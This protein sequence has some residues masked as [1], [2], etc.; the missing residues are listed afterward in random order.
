MPSGRPLTGQGGR[1]GE[2]TGRAA[3][4][5]LG[6][7]PGPQPTGTA[8]PSWAKCR[9]GARLADGATVRGAT[10][11]IGAAPTATT[12]AWHRPGR[13]IEVR[14]ATSLPPVV[15]GSTNDSGLLNTPADSSSRNAPSPCTTAPALSYATTR[16]PGSMGRSSRH[17][18]CSSDP[19]PDQGDVTPATLARCLF[20]PC[21][22]PGAGQ[23]KAR[24]AS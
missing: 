15:P 11:V 24:A 4:S 10:S 5:G 7:D 17:G 22:F 21:P 1:P 16:R 18:Q 19:P 9:C 14:V 13:C 20:D 23:G 2:R 8:L 6:H 12:T 3:R